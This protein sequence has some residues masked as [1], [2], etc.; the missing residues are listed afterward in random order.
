VVEIKKSQAIFGKKISFILQHPQKPQKS[1][2]K[3]FNYF[4]TSI[5]IQ[6]FSIRFFRFLRFGIA[7][8]SLI[9]RTDSFYPGAFNE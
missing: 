6:G 1:A 3:I 4:P 2:K 9:K 5:S 8:K 7:T